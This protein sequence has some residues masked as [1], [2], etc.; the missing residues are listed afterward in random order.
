MSSSSTAQPSAKPVMELIQQLRAGSLAGSSLAIEDRRACVEY[1]TAEGYSVAEVAGMDLLFDR[2]LSYP[3][4]YGGSVSTRSTVSV[5]IH[6]NTRV[7]HRIRYSSPRYP[8]RD[9]P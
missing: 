6:A 3:I 2:R 4:P 5:Q 7:P 1:L 8:A 9:T